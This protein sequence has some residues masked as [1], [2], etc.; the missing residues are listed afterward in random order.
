MKVGRRN[1]FTTHTQTF[2]GRE[3]RILSMKETRAR[4]DMGSTLVST[5]SC[6]SLTQGINDENKCRNAPAIVLPAPNKSTII[7]SH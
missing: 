1:N 6:G 2:Q 4:S 3:L 7:Q 5:A